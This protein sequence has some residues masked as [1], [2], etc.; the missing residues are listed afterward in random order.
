MKRHI[1]AVPNSIC[2][3]HFPLYGILTRTFDYL[4]S[5]CLSLTLKAGEPI[6]DGPID[7]LTDGRASLRQGT[8]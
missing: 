6:Q 5:R 4:E 8:G 3:D 7:Q 2:A 1:A